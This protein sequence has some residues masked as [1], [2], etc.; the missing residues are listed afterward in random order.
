MTREQKAKIYD[1]NIRRVEQLQRENS[2]LSAQ[3]V[4]NIP[5]QV[6]KVIN[7]NNAKINRIVAETDNLFRN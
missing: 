2:K 4:G 3:H 7:E 5:P 6:Q 1:D